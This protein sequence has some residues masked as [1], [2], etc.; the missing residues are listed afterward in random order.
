V[1]Q[2]PD[3]GAL[4]DKFFESLSTIEPALLRNAFRFL[5][6]ILEAEKMSLEMKVAD[7]GELIMEQE[8]RYRRIFENRHIMMFVVDPNSGAIVDANPVDFYG[9]SRERLLSMD[10]FDL[11]AEGREPDLEGLALSKSGQPGFFHRQA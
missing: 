7:D 3:P 4:R 2:I 8:E 5:A 10:L 11:N 6:V 9:Y 1:S